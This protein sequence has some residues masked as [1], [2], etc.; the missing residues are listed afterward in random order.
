MGSNKKNSIKNVGKIE[1]KN[2]GRLNKNENRA[3]ST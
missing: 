1:G 2:M 3:R